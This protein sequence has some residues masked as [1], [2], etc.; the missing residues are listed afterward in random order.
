[1]LVAYTFAACGWEATLAKFAS[2]GT[3]GM[4]EGKGVDTAGK[5]MAGN[6]PLIAWF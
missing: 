5:V 3:A 1:L 4:A 6:A 2:S